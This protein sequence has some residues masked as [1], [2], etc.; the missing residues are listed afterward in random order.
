MSDGGAP[1]GANNEPATS[2]Q[3]HASVESHRDFVAKLFIMHRTSLQR[4][5][6][7]QVRYDIA[8]ELTQEA[9]LRLL[10]Q[11]NALRQDSSARA[12]LYHTATNLARD[13]HRR[14]LSHRTDQHVEINEE[15]IAGDHFGPDEYLAGAQAL[16][17]I[18]NAI[19]ELPTDTRNVLSLRLAHDLSFPKIAQ[20]M[21]VSTRTVS[22]K[23][24]EALGRLGLACDTG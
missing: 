6:S 16:S 13:H 7:R 11:G 8:A 17:A 4:F 23:M 18:E 5:L 21:N 24:T 9:Y 15:D 2:D 20:L 14:R 1:A 19:A 10:R 12:L 3:D 22:R